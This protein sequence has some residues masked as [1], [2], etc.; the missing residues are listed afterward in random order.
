[1]VNIS[2]MS[3]AGWRVTQKLVRNWVS[4][5]WSGVVDKM[6]VCWVIKLLHLQGKAARH[7][8]DEILNPANMTRFLP[9]KHF[10]MFCLYVQEF[11]Y[12]MPLCFVHDTVS[13]NWPSSLPIYLT[14][15][16][17]HDLLTGMLT[18]SLSLQWKTALVLLISY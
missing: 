5:V 9:C 14:H 2:R 10:I 12:A 15:Q 7:I 16:H 3:C 4:C 8:H 11:E 1:M 6:D 18:T 13:Y 17:A